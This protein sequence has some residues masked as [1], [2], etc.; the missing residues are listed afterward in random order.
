[1][2]LTQ[3]AVAKIKLPA[4]KSEHIEW[5]EGLPGFGL[6]LRSSGSK[7]WIVQY[8]IGTQHRRL[9]LGSTAMLTPDEARN[10]WEDE[11]KQKHL[12]AAII[13]A[14]ARHGKDAANDRAKAKE[15]A[16]A[17]KAM[18]AFSEHVKDFLEA[19]L[20]DTKPRSHAEMKRHLEGEQ[21]KPLHGLTLPAIK[22]NMIAERLDYIDKHH[23]R[24]A[25]S[26]ARIS[27]SS[28]FKWSIERCR[29]DENPVI[30]T[31]SLEKPAARE[32]VLTDS[33]LAAIWNNAPANDYGA[34]VR[35]PGVDRAAP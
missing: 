17:G 28:F 30:G 13:L 22:R 23:G 29:C 1:M 5:D 35:A 9:T 21:W 6:R 4:G 11:N 15:T 16:S 26:N 18:K 2:K 10:G 33:E 3:A 20:I 24:V 32:R 34:I 25:A 14:N 31:A 12:G 7:N 27:L 8:K 19:R